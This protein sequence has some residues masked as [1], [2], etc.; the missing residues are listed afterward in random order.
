MEKYRQVRAS[1]GASAASAASAAQPEPRL[2]ASIIAIKFGE[3]L[4]RKDPWQPS[5]EWDAWDPIERVGFFNPKETRP[6][7][8][9]GV[10]GAVVVE[11]TPNG[12]RPLGEMVAEFQRQF[13]LSGNAGDVVDATGEQLGVPLRAGLHL[14]EKAQ[15]CWTVLHG[16]AAAVADEEG[17]AAAAAAGAAEPARKTLTSRDIAKLAQPLLNVERTLYL[18]LK[19]EFTDDATR[20][21][22]EQ[23]Y[24][25]WKRDHKMR[26]HMGSVNPSPSPL[27]PSN[28]SSLDGAMA[29]R[30][31]PAPAALMGALGEVDHED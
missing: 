16:G 22:V 10:G 14:L 8:P 11:P 12:C 29:F 18:Y 26:E 27:P 2:Y 23:A 21:A 19:D 20:A 24:E 7:G 1:A 6:V 9:A 3:K 5:I 17:A 4:K 25:L 30:Q 31:R 13:G 15:R 28:R